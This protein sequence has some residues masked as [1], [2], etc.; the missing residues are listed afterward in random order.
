MA[1]AVALAA[2]GDD[3]TDSPV[4]AAITVDAPPAADAG[5]SDG[6]RRDGPGPSF[7]IQG[8]SSDRHITSGEREISLAHDLSTTAV[9]ALIAEGNGYRTIAGSGDASGT[10]IIRD[11]PPDTAD[12]PRANRFVGVGRTF[13]QTNATSFLSFGRVLLGRHDAVLA[14]SRLTGFI[15]DLDGLE[16]PE[17]TD[18]VNVYSS[19]LPEYILHELGSN[20][21]VA[22]F[23]HP[24][25]IVNAQRGDDLWITQLATRRSTNGVLY[26]GLARVY[27]P[28]PFSTTE[29]QAVT[30]PSGTMVAPAATLV[31]DLDWRRSE[32]HAQRGAVHPEA[33]VSSHRLV[34]Y[35]L[36]GRP[37]VTNADTPDLFY[38]FVSA[39]PDDVDF[40]AVTF[41]NPFPAAWELVGDARATF[42]VSVTAPGATAPADVV[43]QVAV[44]AP[45]AGWNGV[46]VRP[47]LSPPRDPTIGGANAFE[48]RSGVGAQPLLAWRA[49]AIGRPDRYHVLVD[50]LRNEGGDTVLARVASLDIVDDSVRLPPGTLVAGGRYVARIRAV[51][52]TTAD[53]IETVPFAGGMPESSSECVTSPFSP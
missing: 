14:E 16:E 40:G 36:P 47:E 38:A 7:S 19:N 8:A 43:A 29:G 13:M 30:L 5:S 17:P 22:G 25:H 21:T 1:V 20:V 50:E 10:F 9:V 34:I 32:F 6:S 46:A 24:R 37:Q 26:R 33:M 27:T 52:A 31:T 48:P 53:G 23:Y 45:V 49:P 35:A 12:P 42:R 39:E 2:C 4:D 28:T 11:V 44:T 3:D 51:R 41:G 18:L 15:V